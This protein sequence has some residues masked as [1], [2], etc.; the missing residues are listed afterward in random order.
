MNQMNSIDSITVKATIDS[1]AAKYPNAN[2]SDIN[3][4]VK[5]VAIFWMKSDGTKEQFAR[6][7]LDNYITD[8]SQKQ[9]VFEKISRNLEILDGYFN[10]MTVGLKEPIDMNLG[11]IT[12]IDQMFGGYNPISHLSDDLFNNKIAFYILLNFKYYTLAEKTSLG[13]SW[14]RTQWALARLGGLT[15]SRV[16]GELMLKTSVIGAKTDAYINQY[17][18]F[19]GNLVNNKNE[20]LFPSDMKLISHWGLRDQLKANYNDRQGL[21]KQ[22]M[23]Y[24]VMKHII[25]QDIPSEVIN[26]GKYLWNPLSNRLLSNGKDT[27][28]KPE[29]DTRYEWLLKNFKAL[30]AMDTYYP[31]F[32]TYIQLKF[33]NEMEIPQP[34]VEKLFIDL[35]SSGEVKKV[36]GLI[37]KRLG[38]KLEP[39]DIWY[40]GFTSSNDVNTDE[41]DKIIEKKYPNSNAFQ[42]DIPN[43]LIKLGFKPDKAE[44]IASKIQTDAGRGA[45]HAWGAE[46]K[47]DKARLRTRI[48]E[49]GMNYQGFNV[50]M[51]ELGHCVEQTISLYDIDYY[52][53]KGVPNTAFTEALAFI[54]QGRDLDMLGIKN[55]QTDKS[56]LMALDIFWSNY[57]I[58]GV[59]L[60]DMN[61]WKWLYQHPDATKEELKEAVIKIAKEIWN[62]YY[63]DV[64]GVK[65]QPI[66]A[67]YSHMIN[68]PLY[69]SAYPIGYLINFQIEKYMEGKNFAD[70]VMR[71]YSKGR[72]I[73]QLWMK[74]A[75]GEEL[76]NKPLLEAVDKA[77]V[78][79]K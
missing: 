23:I 2:P 17:N 76:S 58:M 30:K 34:D 54:F 72:L 9:V 67:I 71:I 12:P 69:L 43:I 45:G 24:A 32:P 33:D 47:G 36:A 20:K 74:E 6:F 48:G 55:N 29:P 63:A 16:P 73:P 26:S 3:A 38:R 40:D 66:L 4:G 31:L 52:M 65:D 13:A 57:E 14:N 37:E 49:K 53:L 35:V 5:Q 78:K 39:F 44:Y 60:V 28:F 59:S 51:H 77:L 27:S 15:D 8:E 25:N 1:L 70:E 7:C 19:M 18:I 68:F 75:V 10:K 62:K 11:A 41:L 64:F 22:K 42:K 50:A 21:E 61:V 79:I 46:I 56:E